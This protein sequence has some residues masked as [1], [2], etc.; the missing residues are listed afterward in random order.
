MTDS[1]HVTR[2]RAATAVLRWQQTSMRERE[3]ESERERERPYQETMLYCAYI[4]THTPTYIHTDIHA[5][6]HTYI[7]TLCKYTHVCNTYMHT[8][9]HTYIHA[10]IHTYIHAYT[11]GRALAFLFCPPRVLSIH[12]G[13]RG[14]TR[15]GGGTDGG[16]RPAMSQ[17]SAFP[18]LPS[19]INEGKGR[20]IESQGR[21]GKAK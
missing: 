3:R 9:L 6:I 21:E 19:I 18:F 7:H 4:H 12:G 8:Y 17:V 14:G 20:F 2:S 10:Y 15:A 13:G 5:Y 16:E 1:G 11:L